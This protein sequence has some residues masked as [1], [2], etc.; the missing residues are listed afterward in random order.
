[1]R[2]RGLWLASVRYGLLFGAFKPGAAAMSGN[3]LKNPN[4]LWSAS[5]CKHVAAI[6]ESE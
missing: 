4:H 5:E 3:K 6:F 1:M 2:T